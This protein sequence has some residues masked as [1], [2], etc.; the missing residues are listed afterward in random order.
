MCIY[1]SPIDTPTSGSKTTPTGNSAR[2][3]R[4]KKGGSKIDTP[5]QLLFTANDKK[6]NQNN[7]SEQHQNGTGP[8]T[9]TENNNGILSTMNGTVGDTVA[10]KEQEML[11]EPIT[12][13]NGGTTS[14]R[15]P[16]PWGKRDRYT[17]A[18]MG[19]GRDRGG[20]GTL[21]QG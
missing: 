6:M 11:N 4:R 13:Q 1:R 15:T 20:A 19:R 14:S 7:E 5:R 17:G 2:K 21:G 8:T 9:S 12:K 10:Q 18:V 16:Q 3:K